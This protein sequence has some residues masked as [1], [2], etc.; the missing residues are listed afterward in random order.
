MCDKA[1][2]TH[3]STI[4]IVPEYYKTQEL[5]YKAIYG[6]FFYLILFLIDIKLKKYVTYI[7]H[8]YI[9]IYIYITQRMHDEDD[10]DTIILMSLLFWHSKFKKQKSLKER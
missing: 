10:L 6:Y 5:C 1:I 7:L 8:W 9:Y 2:V 4:Q 3:T